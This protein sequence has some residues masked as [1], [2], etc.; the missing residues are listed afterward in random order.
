MTF[1]LEGLLV[2]KEA[3]DIE[4]H[5]TTCPTCR[6]ASE[7]E[8][9]F[10]SAL[11]N[12]LVPPRAPSYLRSQ[13]RAMLIARRKE[14][15]V[16]LWGLSVSALASVL[17]AT[18]VVFCDNSVQL[19]WAVNTHLALKANNRLLDIRTSN[20][21][22]VTD[23]ISRQAD[24]SVQILP[25]VAPQIEI[26]GGRL[27]VDKKDRIIQVA[28][29][30]AGEASSLYAMPIQ[31]APLKG[32][33]V[34]LKEL[35]FHIQKVDGYFTVSWASAKTGYILVSETEQGINRGCLLCHSDTNIKVPSSAFLVES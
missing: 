2:G 19:E 14:K 28:Y 23:W 29:S 1:Y 22:T 26:Q 21:R 3:S 11:R 16:W 10:L 20:P 24:L 13:V 18:F 33:V 12:H 30:G 4:A 34:S 7:A 9:I 8:K 17:I 32:H 35:T 27:I 6:L 25:T 5:L 31:R 15:K